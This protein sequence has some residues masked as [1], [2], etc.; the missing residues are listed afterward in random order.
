L[1]RDFQMKAKAEFLGLAKGD[2]DYLTTFGKRVDI[3]MDHMV[4]R[5]QRDSKFDCWIPDC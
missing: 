4:V 5:W 3:K 2:I 1:W